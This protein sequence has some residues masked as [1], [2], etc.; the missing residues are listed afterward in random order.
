MFSAL[1][2]LK[3]KPKCF[4][5]IRY[6]SLARTFKILCPF[7]CLEW[8]KRHCQNI[9]LGLHF[10]VVALYLLPFVRSMFRKKYIAKGKGKLRLLVVVLEFVGCLRTLGE[11]EFG[12][13]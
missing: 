9:K 5:P 1:I 10:F 12:N 13:E 11:M 4:L 7:V 6:C 8:S 2:F 3:K